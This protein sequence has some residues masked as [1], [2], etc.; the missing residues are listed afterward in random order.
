[1]VRDSLN[2]LHEHRAAEQVRETQLQ[3]KI[4]NLAEHVQRRYHVDL[5]SFTPDALLLKDF[6]RAAQSRENAALSILPKRKR[7]SPS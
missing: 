4:D 5:R 1:M 3:M 6:A 7:S 2:E